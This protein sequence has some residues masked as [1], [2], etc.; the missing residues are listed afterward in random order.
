MANEKRQYRFTIDYYFVRYHT[1][2]LCKTQTR[3][4]VIIAP[5]KAEVLR[6]LSDVDESWIAVANMVFEEVYNCPN[7]GAKMDGDGNG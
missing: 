6:K 1:G 5:N 7:C 4:A 2:N 3:K